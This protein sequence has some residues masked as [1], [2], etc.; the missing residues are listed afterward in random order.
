ML[1]SIP[2]RK[3]TAQ[4]LQVIIKNI[5]V[6]GRSLADIRSFKMAGEMLYS[7]L[8]SPVFNQR[9]SR[10]NIHTFNIL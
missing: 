2:F 6:S 10:I 5:K 1:L 4:Y 8:Y 3:Y 7:E 9:K